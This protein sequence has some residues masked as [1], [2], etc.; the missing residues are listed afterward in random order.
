MKIF[1]DG[2]SVYSCH[3]F[4]ISSASV[5]S[6]PYLSFI[7]PVFAW[8]IPLVS[9][10]FLKRSLVFPNLL[11]SSISLHDRWRRLSYLF[12]LFFGTLHLDTC[13]FPFLLCFSL[14]FFPQLFVKAS[15]SFPCGWSWSLSPAQCHEPHSITYYSKL[16]Y[17]LF[18][19]PSSRIVPGIF[20]A[21]IPVQS[22]NLEQ[23]LILCLSWHL[24][25]WQ[26]QIHWL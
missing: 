11:F 22:L 13:I 7:V 26:A 19:P 6:I 10:I 16:Q 21:I 18:F 15:I 14:L 17:C 25:F 2:A 8:K 20:L 9:L 12:L 23:L 1:L 24:C 4:L 3:L 5:R